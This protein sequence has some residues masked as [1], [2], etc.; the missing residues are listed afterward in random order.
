M[1]GFFTSNGHA[2]R[3]KKTFQEKF[4][5]GMMNEMKKI[6]CESEKEAFLLD[7]TSSMVE[8]KKNGNLFFNGN[9]FVFFV[10]FPFS[11]S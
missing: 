5:L 9:L 10:N 8:L 11:L 1:H 2:T 3:M 7:S 6:K 4:V